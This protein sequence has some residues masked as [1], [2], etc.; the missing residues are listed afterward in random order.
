MSLLIN[1]LQPDV[2][3]RSGRRNGVGDHIVFR[4]GYVG[5]CTGGYR[6]MDHI[7]LFIKYFGNNALII[8][9]IYGINDP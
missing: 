3:L 2:G 7:R 6:F 1:D 4:S 5:Y 8:L 9:N